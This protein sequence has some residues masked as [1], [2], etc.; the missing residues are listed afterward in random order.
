MHAPSEMDFELPAGA[1]EVSGAF[2]FPE[3]AYQNGGRSNGAEFRVIWTDGTDRIVVF[4]RFLNP[5]EVPADR[6]LQHFRAPLKNLA[7]GQLRLEVDPGPYHDNGW[8][9]TAWTGIEIK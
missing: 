6:G 5:R 9:W 3:G 1:Q 8:D 4:S 7:G 2:G